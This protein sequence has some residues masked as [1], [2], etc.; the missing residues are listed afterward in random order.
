MRI[1]HFLYLY[2]FYFLLCRFCVLCVP[3]CG[4]PSIC[5]CVVISS[6]ANKLGVATH[7]CSLG[8]GEAEMEVS[9][10]FHVEMQNNHRTGMIKAEPHN[11]PLLT[12]KS[13]SEYSHRLRFG[14]LDFNLWITVG[15]V[16]WNYLGYC[17]LLLPAVE[18]GAGIVGVKGMW[19]GRM[20][21]KWP[22]RH[23]ALYLTPLNFCL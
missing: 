18:L 2:S 7:T 14:E 19:F 12:I 17:R 21:C 9:P 11:V 6:K 23:L 15:V 5:V 13:V 16:E 4:L 8:A 1:W 20:Y 22:Q 10:G 3:S